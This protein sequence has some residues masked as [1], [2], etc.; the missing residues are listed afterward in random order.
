MQTRM[1]E[2]S[3]LEGKQSLNSKKCL[4]GQ[5]HYEFFDEYLRANVRDRIFASKLAWQ[6]TVFILWQHS[7]RGDRAFD[8]SDVK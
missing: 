4:I 6:Q 3:K 2:S 7:N 5:G 1:M 8:N